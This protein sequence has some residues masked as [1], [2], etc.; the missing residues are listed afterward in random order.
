[1]PAGSGPPKY[2]LEGVEIVISGLPALR[3]NLETA[4]RARKEQLEPVL[5]A[6]SVLYPM[7]NDFFEDLKHGEG[8][9]GRETKEVN[10]R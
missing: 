6:L 7:L 2:L 5:R 3:S 10:A 1:M 9:E 4:S 8:T